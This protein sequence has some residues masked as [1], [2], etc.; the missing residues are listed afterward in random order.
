VPCFSTSTTAHK[1]NTVYVK[2]GCAVQNARLVW[3]SK[4]PCTEAT[5]VSGCV[6]HSTPSPHQ[7]HYAFIPAHARLF[8]IVFAHCY[9]MHADSVVCRDVAACREWIQAVFIKQK[10]YDASKVAQLADRSPTTNNI[11]TTYVAH[12]FNASST[13]PSP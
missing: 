8:S 6:W 9:T 3:L 10:Y 2:A 5:P 13:P 11:A 12:C 7:M 4:M 1:P